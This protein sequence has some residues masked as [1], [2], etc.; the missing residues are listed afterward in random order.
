MRYHV[1]RL[2]LTSSLEYFPTLGV[3]AVWIT[4]IFASPMADFGYDISDYRWGVQLTKVILDKS[5][6]TMAGTI[7]DIFSFAEQSI[8]YLGQW[9]TLTS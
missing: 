8:R 2:G 7:V 6:L 5:N 3:D 9:K 4:P 1:D